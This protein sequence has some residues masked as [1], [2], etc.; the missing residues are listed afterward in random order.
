MPL[1]LVIV[2][3]GRSEGNEANSAS[4]KGDNRHFT[5]E[6]RARHGSQWRLTGLGCRQADA[7]GE[8]L[9]ANNLSRFD[10]YYT[11]DYIRARETAVHLDLPDASWFPAPRLRE[12]DW[13]GLE[14]IPEQERL[15][16]FREE[17]ERRQVQPFYWRP[18]YGESMADL[19][20]RIDM[21]LGTL[22]RECSDKRVIIV[23]HGEV[24][25]GFRVLL[26]RMGQERYMELDA[27]KHPFD[28]IHNCQILHYT[29]RDPETGL[30]TPYYNW[31]CSICPWN[32][33]LSSNEWQPIERK[34]YSNEELRRT[35]ERFPQL[36]T[37]G[38]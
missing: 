29:R 37:E 27:S 26:E 30:I 4:R 9:R 34:R 20:D 7:A 21:V 31:M 6:Y 33:A 19:T 23:C 38:A 14:S 2:R 36:V 11:S 5:E 12:R 22:S 8:W 28:K 3:H 16:K 1:D 13:G 32:T 15:D 10:R 25:W 35:V 17:I 18:P 24:M